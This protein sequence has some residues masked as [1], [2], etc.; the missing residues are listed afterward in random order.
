MRVLVTGAA[1]LCGTHLVDELVRDKEISKVYGIDNLSRGFPRKEEFVIGEQWQGKFELIVKKY[2]DLSVREINNLDVDVVVHLAAYNSAREAMETP[3]EYFVNNDYGTMKLLQKLFHTKKNPFFIFASAAEIYGKPVKEPVSESSAPTAMNIFAAT[4]LAGENYCSVFFNWYNYPL[5]VIRLSKVYGENQ[6]LV[7]YTSVVG[8][9]ICRALRDDP[10]IIYGCGGQ[11]RDFIYAGDVAKA[12]T[13]IIKARKKVCGQ[14]INIAS[15]KVISIEELA[16]N[17]I[18]LSGAKS[19]IIK[20][21]PVKGDYPGYLLDISKACELLNW[22]ASTP[23]DVGLKRTI[24]WHRQ[25]MNL[26]I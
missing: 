16:R 25:V 1:G 7:G 21:P 15:G 4:K 20:L 12:I 17:I 14:V 18:D 23:L 19:E 6:N 10:L 8:N 3:D 2:Q 26:G 5:A 11:T 22:S 9:F 13:G 24:N